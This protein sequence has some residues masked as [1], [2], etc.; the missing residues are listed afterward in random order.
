MFLSAP[1]TGKTALM[2]TEALHCIEEGN[3]VFLIPHGG[4]FNKN[5]KSLL[6]LKFE[7]FW[8][9]LKHKHQWKYELQTGF[10]KKK[11]FF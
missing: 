9:A 6:T 1:S 3:V 11:H 8:E 10:I 5:F 4:N 2:E 7:K